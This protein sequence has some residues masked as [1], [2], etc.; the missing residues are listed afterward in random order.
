MKKRKKNKRKKTPGLKNSKVYSLLFDVFIKNPTLFFNYRQLSKKL[1]LTGLSEKTQV[2]SVL[3]ELKKNNVVSELS[4]GKYC[5]SKKTTHFVSTV[6]KS[7]KNGVYVFSEEF[8]EVYIPREFSLF[9]LMEDVVSVFVLKKKK[10]IFLG[11]VSEVLERKKSVFVGSIDVSS[12]NGFLVP[13][14]RAVYFD[15]FIKNPSSLSVFLN[16]K[17]LCEVVSWDEK[18]KNPFGK[19]I[20]TIGL[21]LDPKAELSS[22]LYDH[23]L[24]ISFPKKITDLK[25]SFTEKIS[26]KEINKRLDLRAVPT[27]TIDPEDAKDFD[28]ALSIRKTK[29]NLYEV[30]VHIA[31]V[32]H[33]V[34]EKSIIDIEAQKRSTSTYLVDRVVPMLP[35]FLSNNICSLKPSVDRLAFSVIFNIDKQ[36]TVF[37]YTIKK[38]VIKSDFRFSYEEAE[39]TIANKCGFF[40]DE[41]LVLSNISKKLK[42]VRIKKGS[43][44]FE[45]S[46]TKFRLNKKSE[47]IE[48][49]YKTHLSTHSLIEEFMLLANKTVA[50]HFL[51]FKSLV[52]PFLYRVHD[53]PDKEKILNLAFIVKKLGYSLSFN[54]PKSLSFSINNLLKKTKGS[55]EQKMIETLVVRSMSKAVYSTK[56]KGHYGLGFKNYTHFTSPIRRYADLMVHRI[57]YNIITGSEYKNLKLDHICSHC[58]LMEKRSSSAERSSINYMQVLYLKNKLG[59]VFSGIISGVVEWGLYVTLNENGCEGLIPVSELKDDHYVFDEKNHQLK[60]YNTNNIYRLGEEINIV[61]KKADLIKKQLSFSFA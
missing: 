29:N 36:G 33:Y 24:P 28:D 42:A 32:S 46:E 26:Q 8:G 48:T 13:D 60:G 6:Y 17:V 57:L 35:E 40:I 5:L 50:K 41:L 3:K 39:K 37:D 19:I 12:G 11:R 55:P 52:F 34:S 44:L 61:V 31:D 59:S 51:S 30:G 45:N 58:S 7:S 53:V 20:K 9:S 23:S 21:S 43:I 14:N 49:F 18:Y 22:I 15:I 25:D 2:V 1:K 27:L 56:N 10:N 54:S 16:K 4:L 47:P 38:T